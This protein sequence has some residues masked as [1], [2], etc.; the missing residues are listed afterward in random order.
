MIKVP[1]TI[2]RVGHGVP[3]VVFYPYTYISDIYG[4]GGD[5]AKKRLRMRAVDSLWRVSERLINE[6]L[7]L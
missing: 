6:S 3:G 4:L 5:R 1:P 7:L 2:R